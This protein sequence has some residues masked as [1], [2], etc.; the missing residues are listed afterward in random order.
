[1]PRKDREVYNAY[2]RAYQ[3]KQRR[4]AGVP[5]RETPECGTV[6][7]YR[8]HKRLGEAI[9]DACRTAWN[10]YCRELYQRRKGS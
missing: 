7:G 1:M 8:R 4:A 6:G 9:C 10:T 5:K 2:M 3:A